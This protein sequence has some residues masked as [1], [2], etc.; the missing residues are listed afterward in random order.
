MD[1]AIGVQAGRICP[2]CR[3]ENSVPLISGVPS[4]EVIDLAERGLV[5]L[6]GCMVGPE[7]P[8]LS[9]RSCGKKWAGEER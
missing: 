6:G 9:C 1:Q 8:D 5:T 7:A 4:A 2:D 3:A